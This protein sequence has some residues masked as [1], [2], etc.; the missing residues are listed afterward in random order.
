MEGNKMQRKVMKSD[1]TIEKY[2]HTK[3]LA[4]LN[5]ALVLIDQPNVFAAEQFADAI[6]YYFY[7]DK[8]ASIISTD[9]I[10]LMIISVL[11]A[12]GYENAAH[13]LTEHRLQRR[14]RRNRIEV[15][16]PDAR[17]PQNIPQRWDKSRIVQN[18]T[19]SKGIEI[20]LARAI[21][22]GV[23]EKVLN[24]DVNNITTNLIREIVYAETSAMIRAQDQLLAA[25][26]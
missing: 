20:D 18:L 3:V 10:H 13:A 6:T 1:G 8:N 17:A 15:F 11:N 2:K 26:G 12:T 7:R 23:E 21:A 14:L 5:H 24:M 22:A 4:S 9:D 19:Y 16:N 25:A